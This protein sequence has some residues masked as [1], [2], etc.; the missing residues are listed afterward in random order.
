[1]DYYCL[2]QVFPP[3]ITAGQNIINIK[4]LR[5]LPQ[6]WELVNLWVQD[7]EERKG[8]PSE[9]SMM[10]AIIFP[11]EIIANSESGGWKTV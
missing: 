2:E 1:M 5:S 6:Q 8:N 9:V 3:L 11:P 4:A 7:L 10:F